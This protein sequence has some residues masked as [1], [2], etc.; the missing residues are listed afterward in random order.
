VFDFI[1]NP[2]DSIESPG[3]FSFV[4][5]LSPDNFIGEAFFGSA[6]DVNQGFA[7]IGAKFDNSIVTQAGEAYVYSNETNR[8]SWNLSRSREEKVDIESINRVFVYDKTKQLILTNLDNYDPLKGK[9][10]GIAEQELDFISSFDPAKYN[11]AN[12]TIDVNTPQVGPLNLVQTTDVGTNPSWGKEQ[13]GKLWWN[14]DAVRY[15]DYEQDSLTYRSRTWGA[16]FPGSTIEICEWIESD[17]PP[18]SYVGEGTVKYNDNTRYSISYY[19]DRTTG[20][21]KAKYYYWVFNKFS[22]EPGSNKTLS[23]GSVAEIIEN[24]QTAGVPYI[25]AIRND[26]FN[27]Y[28]VT[29][30]LSGQDSI[31]QINYNLLRNDNNIIHSE[32]HLIKEGSSII[33]PQQKII[34]KFIDSLCGVT[35]D[36]SLVPDPALPASQRYGIAS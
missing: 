8:A 36:G 11:Q 26:A 18:G 23:A 6:I 25:A 17:L 15:L 33:D 14:L 13:V 1:S 35:I 21:V 20:L 12:P 30:Y 7:V 4:Q 10:L 5:Q 19:V 31:L 16:V 29:R 3:Q 24:P 34:Q 9:I 2:A 22:T 28:H 32:Y 27:L